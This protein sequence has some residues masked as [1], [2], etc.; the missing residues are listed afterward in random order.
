MADEPKVTR[1]TWCQAAETALRPAAGSA[2]DLEVIR[3]DV[4]TDRCTELYRVTGPAEGWLVLRLEGNALSERE[5]VIVLGAGRGIRPVIP[6]IQRYARTLGATVR[7][8][9]T[10]DGLARIYKGHGFHRAE[11]VM[12]WR[13]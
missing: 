10:R 8:H 7:T 9:I 6:I 1:A 4:R 2:H 13:P 12:R 11:I 3:A 5:L